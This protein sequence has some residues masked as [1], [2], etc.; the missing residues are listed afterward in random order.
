MK[1][2]TIPHFY[3]IIKSIYKNNSSILL[4]QSLNKVFYKNKNKNKKLHFLSQI[5]KQDNLEIH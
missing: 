4:T 3:K 2:K 5:E 1:K